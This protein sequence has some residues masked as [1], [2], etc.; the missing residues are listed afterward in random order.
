MYD[1]IILIS[2]KDKQDWQRLKSKVIGNSES[3]IMI[4]TPDGRILY[5][6]NTTAPFYIINENIG[7]NNI[8]N[9]LSSI[10]QL[11]SGKTILIAVHKT[12]FADI[13]KALPNL[14]YCIY[15]PF[16]HEDDYPIWSDY[17]RPFIDAVVSE[18]NA[19]EALIKLR[20]FDN[21]YLAHR[22]RSELLTPFIPFHLACQ[23][24]DLDEW[25]TLL[26]QSRQ[27]MDVAVA[28]KNIDRL[29]TLLPPIAIS[30]DKRNDFHNRLLTEVKTL[31]DFCNHDLENKKEQ[32]KSAVQQF[33]DCLETVV[34]WI[35]F[36]DD[37]ECR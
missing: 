17:L 28:N 16:H 1:V 15:Q 12:A 4:V 22:F 33:A 32:I 10:L 34:N 13:E 36:G 18:T 8:K 5:F 2:N 25:T 6:D 3:S 19:K 7:P 23:T 24:R 37:A 26:E 21:V 29:V 11:N 27:L 9:R 31:I 14:P 20:S 30:A 35:E